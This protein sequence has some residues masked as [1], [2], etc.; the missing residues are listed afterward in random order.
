MENT[1]GIYN[2]MAR[3]TLTD[4]QLS[5]AYAEHCANVVKGKWDK[6]ECILCVPTKGKDGKNKDNS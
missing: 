2:S 6:C 5:D 4:K 3:T 1:K